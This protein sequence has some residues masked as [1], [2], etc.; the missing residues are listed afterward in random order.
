M[1][2]NNDLIKIPT[3]NTSAQV[4]S[5]YIDTINVNNVIKRGKI[6]QFV[7][8]GSIIYFTND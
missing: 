4:N 1:H 2:I 3:V 5:S 7:F 8:N 6:V